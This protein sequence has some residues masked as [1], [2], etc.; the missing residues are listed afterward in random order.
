MSGNKKCSQLM[1]KVQKDTSEMQEFE[2]PHLR[3]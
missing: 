2:R 1:S 3:Q